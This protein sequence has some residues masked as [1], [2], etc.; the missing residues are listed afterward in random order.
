M[1]LDPHFL[2][3]SLVLVILDFVLD[4]LKE[5]FPRDLEHLKAVL[6]CLEELLEVRRNSS[7][8]TQ[9]RP[10]STFIANELTILQPSG[11]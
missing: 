9:K 2:Q 6:G 11:G 3:L 4:L 8:G 1:L 10:N 5:V 7:D